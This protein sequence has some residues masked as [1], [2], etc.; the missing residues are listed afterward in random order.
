MWAVVWPALAGRSGEE[1]SPVSGDLVTWEGKQPLVQ[2][3]QGAMEQAVLRACCPQ[4]GAVR[5]LSQNTLLGEVDGDI[6]TQTSN[7]AAPFHLP[8]A[9]L[10]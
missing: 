6:S 3:H 9:L 10:R 2:A 5:S 4:V 8:P 7:A 1:I